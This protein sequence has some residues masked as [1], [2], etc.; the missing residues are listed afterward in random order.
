M[1]PNS[2]LRTSKFRVQGV[3]LLR[4]SLRV[5]TTGGTNQ[6]LRKISAFF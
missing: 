4:V 5:S 6:V 2:L 1:F 3:R